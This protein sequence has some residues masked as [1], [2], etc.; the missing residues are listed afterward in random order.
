[1]PEWLNARPLSATLV[2]PG[3]ERTR[4]HPERPA[5]PAVLGDADHPLRARSR[6]E[7][8]VAEVLKVSGRATADAPSNMDRPGGSQLRRRLAAHSPAGLV[9]SAFPAP[10]PS[11]LTGETSGVK[12]PL[13]AAQPAG[14]MHPINHSR[15]AEVVQVPVDPGFTERLNGAKNSF[16]AAARAHRAS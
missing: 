5:A 4:E 8:D 10:L 15:A 16:D 14:G 3:T 11:F 9:P 12:I 2:L 13:G 7:P 1:M 6:R